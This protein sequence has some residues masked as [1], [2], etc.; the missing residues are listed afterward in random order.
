MTRL[1]LFKFTDFTPSAP[2]ANS[3][4]SL[5]HDNDLLGIGVTE[6]VSNKVSKFSYKITFVRNH[7][8]LHAYAEL[9]GKC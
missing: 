5:L 6:N 4:A 2:A 9:C 3:G 8:I 7:C 1:F